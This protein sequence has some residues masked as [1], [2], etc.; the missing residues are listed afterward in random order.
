MAVVQ[1]VG[2]GAW[3]S[4][5]QSDGPHIAGFLCWESSTRP[6]HR[7]PNIRGLPTRT[8]CW[9]VRVLVARF[10]VLYWR[11]AEPRIAIAQADHLLGRKGNTSNHFW[12]SFLTYWFCSFPHWSINR[13]TLGSEKHSSP[14]GETHASTRGVEWFRQGSKV[15]DEWF[16]VLRFWKLG[17]RLPSVEGW[18]NRSDWTEG[19]PFASPKQTTSDFQGKVQSSCHCSQSVAFLGRRIC[20]Q[21]AKGNRNRIKSSFWW[22]DLDFFLLVLEEPTIATSFI[23]VFATPLEMKGRS[24]LHC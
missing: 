21:I 5:F 15:R 22:W 10:F 2:V 19:F 13:N 8:P 14:D 7:F 3:I 16:H 12:V 9:A 17:I 11:I 24:M 1:I 18:A 20:R 6:D 4:A 23:T